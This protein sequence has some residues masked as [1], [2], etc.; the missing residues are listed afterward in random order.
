[1]GAEPKMPE[2]PVNKSNNPIINLLDRLIRDVKTHR[3]D[4]MKLTRRSFFDMSK[5]D[6]LDVISR[7]SSKKKS[8]LK[9]SC[10]VSS[11]PPKLDPRKTPNIS[12]IGMKTKSVGFLEKG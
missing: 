11:V 3:D 4:K 6:N 2:E 7:K 10:R 12:K 5:Q 8:V 1:M 9:A